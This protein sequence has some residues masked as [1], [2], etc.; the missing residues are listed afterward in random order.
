MA[1]RG[2]RCRASGLRPQHSKD[3]LQN[4][5]TGTEG[6]TIAVDDQGQ[7]P[8]QR[9][10]LFD[11][12]RAFLTLRSAR[13]EMSRRDARREKRASSPPRPWPPARCIR[14]SCRDSGRHLDVLDPERHERASPW[15]FDRGHCGG[16]FAVDS[17]LEGGVSCELVSENAQIPLLAGKI[18]GISSIRASA[19]PRRQP[20]RA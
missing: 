12:Y 16:K 10:V 2:R 17:P 15:R 7:L 20:K 13:R 4:P 18:Q 19:A 8:D 9:F 11:P 1:A 5:D 14:A 6:V 3:I